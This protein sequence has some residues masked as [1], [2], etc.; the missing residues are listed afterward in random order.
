MKELNNFE[1]ISINGGEVSFAKK[2]GYFAAEFVAVTA[3]CVVW[4][5]DCTV[6]VIKTIF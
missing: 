3:A 4:V 6:D 2:A 5:A 1:L